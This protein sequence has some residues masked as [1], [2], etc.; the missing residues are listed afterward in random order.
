MKSPVSID[1]KG[2]KLEVSFEQNSDGSFSNIWLEG[3]A[4]RV[5]KGS[6]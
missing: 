3:P 2:G 4:L 5:F 6:W 1:T